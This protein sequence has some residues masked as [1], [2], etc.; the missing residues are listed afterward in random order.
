[1][2]YGQLIILSFFVAVVSAS[3]VWG[4]AKPMKAGVPAMTATDMTLLVNAG[5]LGSQPTQSQTQNGTY[6]NLSDVMTSPGAPFNGNSQKNTTTVVGAS[7]NGQVN[8]PATYAKTKPGK[9]G[10]AFN[11]NVVK[12][13]YQ[14]RIL[15]N[16]DNF[17]EAASINL[18]PNDN[19]EIVDQMI[20]AIIESA[21][22]WGSTQGLYSDAVYKGKDI[23][24]ENTPFVMN[25]HNQLDKLNLKS[26]IE[27]PDPIGILA[28]LI[29]YATGQAGASYGDNFLLFYAL[30]NNSKPAAAMAALKLAYLFSVDN[31]VKQN[32][33]V[34]KA[35]YDNY[36]LRKQGN[37][38]GTYQF[39][40]NRH[41]MSVPFK[42][43]GVQ[44]GAFSWLIGKSANAQS[45]ALLWDDQC[46]CPELDL[47]TTW[48]SSVTPS[49]FIIP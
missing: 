24:K 7:I 4:Q 25:M 27:G 47:F 45:S 34:F 3:N 40:A 17:I 31:V 22:V 29:Q 15:N 11:A 44:F 37:K 49:S 26:L 43:Y 38:L 2:N 20:Y 14:K 30:E 46:D 21:K 42:R 33:P 13:L 12:D 32:D 16:L 9:Y 19:K 23:Y 35:L 18:N 48:S 8:G 6:T 1:M 36:V 10:I 39:A 5:T 41:G 28:P